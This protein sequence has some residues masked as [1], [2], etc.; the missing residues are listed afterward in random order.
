MKLKPD[1][2]V[3]HVSGQY[4]VFVKADWLQEI[5][6][7]TAEQTKRIV[8]FTD[9]NVN[10]LYG[11]AFLQEL[12]RYSVDVVNILVPPGE[13]SKSLAVVN[14]IYDALLAR[15]VDRQTTMVALGGGVVGD[16]A[17]FVAATWM[18]GIDLIQ[19]P[20]TL[21]AQ[22]DSSVGGKTGVN[23]PGAKN[24]VGAFWQPVSVFIDTSMLESL[25]EDEFTSGLAEVVK[26]GA[27]LDAELFKLLES[28]VEMINK[29]FDR[30]GRSCPT[31]L[32]SQGRSC[33]ARRA[34]NNGPTCRAELWTYS[35][36]RTGIGF[37][38]RKL[39]ARAR[40]RRRND[41]CIPNGSTA[42]SGE[43]RFCRSIVETASFPEYSSRISGQPA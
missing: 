25:G 26:Y 19:I 15:G 40:S 16:I 37:W 1:L 31:M 22:V 23:L 17:G 2:V 21:L 13:S 18:R 35:G 39:A 30:Y 3:E 5:A 38:L 12:A 9:E 33:A 20:T 34:R 36:A 11:Q 7:A 28:Q 24:I 42:W 41:G 8:L 4:P 29:R 27:I 6:H 10:G 32:Q 43:G 14:G